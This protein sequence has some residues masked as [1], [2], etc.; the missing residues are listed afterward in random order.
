MQYHV[1]VCVDSLESLQNAIEGG[2]TRIELCSSLDLGGLTP[3]YGLMKQA[4]L[5]SGEVPVYGMIRPRQGDFLYCDED[6]E[7]MK[8]DIDAAAT[9]GIQGVV[10]GVLA[11]NGSIDLDKAKQLVDRAKQHELG[12]TFHRAIDQC[13]DFRQAIDD[14]SGLG[15]ER[16]L[17]SGLASKAVQGKQVIKEMVHLANGRLQIMAGAGVN[18]QNVQEIVQSTGVKEVHLSGKCTR[19]SKMIF[20][21]SEATMGS[22][23]D[24]LVPVTSREAIVGVVKALHA[25]KL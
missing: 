5:L 14:I 15:F 23:D 1:E 24:F 9:S 7:T 18:T 4:V 13:R 17:T 11:E 21:S 8:L 20:V 3:S 16:I 2:A 6:I 22:I 12:T 19:P 25:M 10:F